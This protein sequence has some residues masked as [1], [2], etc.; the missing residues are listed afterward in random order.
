VAAGLVP[1]KPVKIYIHGLEDSINNYPISF[2]RQIMRGNW[3]SL[4]QI[5]GYLN[6]R[7]VDQL[8]FVVVIPDNKTESFDIFYNRFL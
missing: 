7:I 3:T 2:C 8:V 4:D 1:G 6:F 5:Y